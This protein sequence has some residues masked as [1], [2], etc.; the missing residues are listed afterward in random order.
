MLDSLETF[1]DVKCVRDKPIGPHDVVILG[2]VRFVSYTHTTSP[3]VSGSNM[4]SHTTQALP[5]GLLHSIAA[6]VVKRVS[7]ALV[8][9]GA[10][11][12]TCQL[13]VGGCGI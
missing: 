1:L 12:R 2:Q 7:T 5:S 3:T 11:W 4:I 6:C 10:T 9:S 13:Q 8:V